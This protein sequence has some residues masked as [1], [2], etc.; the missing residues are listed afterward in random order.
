MGGAALS[1]GARTSL[2]ALAGAA[3]AVVSTYMSLSAWVAARASESGSVTPTSMAAAPSPGV[4]LQIDSTPENAT[5]WARGRSF[6]PVFVVKES[7]RERLRLEHRACLDEI[8]GFTHWLELDVDRRPDGTCE[9][10]L[11]ESHYGGCVRLTDGSAP[12]GPKKS[13]NARVVLTRDWLDGTEEF[14]CAIYARSADGREPA[15]DPD[16]YRV[17]R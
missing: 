7:T 8:C 3:V 1:R 14:G 12:A 9:A 13:L 5:R 10:T 16:W 17:W 11:T 4:V 6:A 2:V 15:R